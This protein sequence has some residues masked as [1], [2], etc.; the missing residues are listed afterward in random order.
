LADYQA[1]TP[2]K[3]IYP[4]NP[5]AAAIDAPRCRRSN[6]HA[7]NFMSKDLFAH[8]AIKEGLPVLAQHVIPWAR[9]GHGLRNS[10]GK[11]C[12]RHGAPNAGQLNCEPLARCLCVILGFEIALA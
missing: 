5:A 12:V 6:Q 3:G 10:E 7:R 4:V 8:Y 1:I 2:I 9:R 11:I